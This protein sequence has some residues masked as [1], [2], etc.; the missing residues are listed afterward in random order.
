MHPISNESWN[1]QNSVH[2]YTPEEFKRRIV[3]IDPKHAAK[4]QVYDILVATYREGS[5]LKKSAENEISVAKLL[6]LLDDKKRNRKIEYFYKQL[7]NALPAPP[8]LILPYTANKQQRKAVLIERLAKL[9]DNLDSDEKKASYKSI[10]GYYQDTKK[11]I[12]Y[13]YFWEILAIPFADPIHAKKRIDFIGAINYSISPKTYGSLFE[14]EYKE[15]SAYNDGTREYDATTNILG[16]LEHYGFHEYATDSAKIPCLVVANLV[17]PRRDP[18]GQDKS[19]ID[20]S[21][22]TET[23]MEGVKRIASEIKSFHA[24]GYSFRKPEERRN[25]I[26]LHSSSGEKSLKDL[27]MDYLRKEHGLVT[28]NKNNNSDYDYEYYAEEKKDTITT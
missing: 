2:S 17:T 8:K 4:T 14:G 18:H 24:L 5:N 10:H 3:N 15:V 6:S 13:P 11:G 16:V 7:Q 9:Y 19:R 25:A 28:N 20:T 22:F 27:L 12:A 21:P 1:K 26:R 23:I